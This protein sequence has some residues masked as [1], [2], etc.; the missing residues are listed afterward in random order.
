VEVEVKDRLP[1][2]RSARV[3]DVEPIRF[4]RGPDARGEAARGEC[5]PLQ[6]VVATIPQKRQSL[7]IGAAA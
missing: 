2:G 7:A 6:V 5:G 1:G 3:E 4:E